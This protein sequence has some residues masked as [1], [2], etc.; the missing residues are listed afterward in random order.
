M[1]V[2]LTKNRNIEILIYEEFTIIPIEIEERQTSHLN[3]I[4]Y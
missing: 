3:L 1:Q 2:V 4:D